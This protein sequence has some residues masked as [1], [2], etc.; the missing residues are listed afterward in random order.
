MKKT[1]REKPLHGCYPLRTDNGDD[2]KTT[3]HQWLSSSSIKGETED[4]TLAAQ[5]QSLA[6]RVY[7]AKILKN[8]ADP[9]CRLCTHSEETI[10]HMISGCPTIANTEYLQR[11]DQVAKFIHRTLCKHYEIPHTERWYKHTLEPVVEGKNVTILWDFTVQTDRKIDA[12]RPDIIIKNHEERTCI[13]MD[14]PVPSDQ[15]I[16]LKEFPKLSKYKDLEIEVS[17]MWKLKK[18]IIPVLIGA[19]EMIKKRTQNFID[20]IPGKPSL[21]EMQ[22]IVLTSTAHILRKVLS[23]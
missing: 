8:G 17:K 20:Q 7:Q 16:S 4:F 13:M 22:N 23:I 10:D 14:V 18:K 15:N 1:W 9:K 12:N 3:T 5:D 11:H 6:T 19:L 21:Q 2:D